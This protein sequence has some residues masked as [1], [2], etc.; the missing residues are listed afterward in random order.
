MTAKRMHALK[1]YAKVLLQIRL[2]LQEI[3]VQIQGR[4]VV[5]QT[6]I[7]LLLPQTNNSNKV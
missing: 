2:V 4:N 6:Q 7:Q 5:N 3:F 1:P